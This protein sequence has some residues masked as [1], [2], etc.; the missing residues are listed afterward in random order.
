MK[1]ALRDIRHPLETAK[2]GAKLLI[3]LFFSAVH[4]I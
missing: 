3:H 2:N 4:Q 1:F